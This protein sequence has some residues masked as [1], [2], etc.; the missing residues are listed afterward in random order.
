MDRG[1]PA[2][3]IV[4]A[5]M[6]RLL[7]MR[8]KLCG[9]Q[10]GVRVQ[11]RFTCLCQGNWILC[12]HCPCP[13]DGKVVAGGVS[14]CCALSPPSDGSGVTNTQQQGNMISSIPRNALDTHS[15]CKAFSLA[16][17]GA[18]C[19]LRHWAAAASSE[20]QNLQ[21]IVVLQGGGRWLEGCQ[22]FFHMSATAV[23]H[24]TAENLAVE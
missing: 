17:P 7:C 10:F 2:P 11:G 3:P 20:G 18:F 8:G 6:E 13:T 15:R 22:K 19:P 5:V 1:A 14:Q 23:R 21:G 24:A 12:S 16:N 4:P 9:D